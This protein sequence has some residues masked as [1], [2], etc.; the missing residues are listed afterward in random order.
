M[1]KLR[2][3]FKTAIVS[4]ATAVMLSA[5]SFAQVRYPFKNVDFPLTLEQG[6]NFKV[7]V[8]A[9]WNFHYLSF[10]PLPSYEE[11]G[12]TEQDHRSYY[13]WGYT[14]QDRQEFSD[15]DV[16][17]QQRSEYKNVQ[18]VCW[19]QCNGDENAKIYFSI[20]DST[21]NNP[22]SLDC[23]LLF[24]DNQSTPVKAFIIPGVS[25][26]GQNNRMLV[27]WEGDLFFNLKPKERTWLLLV[28][29]VPADLKE[30]KFRLKEQIIPLSIPEAK[31]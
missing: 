14:N 15:V 20:N 9:Y 5:N 28:F 11:D 18:L 22:T 24:G 25:G 4:I 1:I 21:A 13:N 8:Y 7:D 23:S 31:K 19:F 2:V 3:F 10:L 16:G 29:R 12:I 27:G 26:I 6:V 17:S 30:A